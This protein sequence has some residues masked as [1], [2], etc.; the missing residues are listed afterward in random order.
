LLQNY[1]PGELEREIERFVEY[2]NHQRAHESL[3]NVT[4]ADMLFGRAAAILARREATKRV[5][6]QQR[7]RY[8]LACRTQE[9][10]R[11]HTL[12]AGRKCPECFDDVQ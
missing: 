5:T 10:T 8:N 2:Y 1:L 7:R 12:N 6:I 4:P 11:N 3:N 9:Q